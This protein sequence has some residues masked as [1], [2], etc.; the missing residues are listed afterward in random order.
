MRKKEKKVSGEMGAR[1][2]REESGGIQI[3][4]IQFK[5]ICHCNWTAAIIVHTAPDIV[6]SECLLEIKASRRSTPIRH[7]P[8]WRVAWEYSH[9]GLCM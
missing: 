5:C 8:M 6:I 9:I 1:A 3:D 7:G 4:K 2:F